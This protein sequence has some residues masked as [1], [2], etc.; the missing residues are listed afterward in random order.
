MQQ[1]VGNTDPLCLHPDNWGWVAFFNNTFGVQWESGQQT[2]TE[3]DFVIWLDYAHNKRSP[4]TDKEDEYAQKL[5]QWLRIV[6]DDG[7][8][9]DMYSP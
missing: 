2:A 3:E 9:I 8:Y 1:E 7:G 4:G 6:Q 5:I